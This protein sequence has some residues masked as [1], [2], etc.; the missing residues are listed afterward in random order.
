MQG[1]AIAICPSICS[2]TR[3]CANRL[4]VI[5][6]THYAARTVLYLYLSLFFC[7]HLYL[8][9]YLYLYLCASSA[10]DNEHSLSCQDCITASQFKLPAPIPA[11]FLSLS[12]SLHFPYPPVSFSCISCFVTRHLLNVTIIV[13]RPSQFKNSN[14]QLPCQ[15]SSS[16]FQLPFISNNHQHTKDLCIKVAIIVQ[17]SLLLS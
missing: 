11:S 5:M 9:F 16:L 6:N 1:P 3:T 10:G 2:R 7:L 12:T 8:C 13:M 15:P 14:Y 17:K 4:L